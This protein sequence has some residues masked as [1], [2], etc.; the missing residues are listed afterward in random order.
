MK[1]LYDKTQEVER[2]QCDLG[3]LQQDKLLMTMLIKKLE[4]DSA[5]K[6]SYLFCCLPLSVTLNG[7]L[8]RCSST[9]LFLFGGHI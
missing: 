9:K 1:E 4:E 3:R 5:A 6:V 8:Q 2:L 7:L